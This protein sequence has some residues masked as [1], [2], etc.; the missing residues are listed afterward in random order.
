MRS[1]LLLVALGCSG[2]LAGQLKGPVEDHYI[3]TQTIAD[4]C[5][6]GIYDNGPCGVDL[7]ED[8]DAMAKQAELLNNIVTGTAPK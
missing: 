3:Q 4:R 8:V 1:T 5:R 7:Q 6:E 2:C